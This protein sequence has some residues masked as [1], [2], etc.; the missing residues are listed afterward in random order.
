MKL[1]TRSR[2]AVRALAEI[3]RNYGVRST[4]RNEIVESEGISDSYL[5]DLL[6][7]CKNS[8]LL[9]TA[10][11]SKGGYVLTRPPSRITMLDII[12]SQ[13]GSLAPVEC[14][15]NTA[16]C[17]RIMSCSTRRVWELFYTAIKNSLSN[18]TLEDIIKS[19]SDCEEVRKTKRKKQC[20]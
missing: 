11:G 16:Y 4:K 18:I 15:N 14:I 5:E 2:Y 10:R 7:A 8:G 20:D 13:E 6:V 19:G 3:A 12:T 1:T 17:D 9:F